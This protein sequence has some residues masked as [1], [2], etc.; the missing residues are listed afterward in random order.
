MN[1]K[2]LVAHKLATFRNADSIVVMSEGSNYAVIIFF[3]F[4]KPILAMHTKKISLTGFGVVFK[5]IAYLNVILLFM[6]LILGLYS[7]WSIHAVLGYFM[8]MKFIIH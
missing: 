8:Y 7:T 3:C 5:V 2:Q 4:V 6:W 1:M